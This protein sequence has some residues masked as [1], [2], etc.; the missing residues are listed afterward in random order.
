MKFKF[1]DRVT[2]ITTSFYGCDG[3]VNDYMTSGAVQVALDATSGYFLFVEDELELVTIKTPR[4]IEK[5]HVV[6]A[7][8][9]CTHKWVNYQPLVGEAYECC[10]LAGCGIKKADYREVET[11]TQSTYEGQDGKTYPLPAGNTW[12]LSDW[13]SGVWGK[14]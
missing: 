10:A 12:N 11:K 13:P 2:V 4:Q 14:L 8:P 7:A 1:G 6:T 3:T 9:S 5:S